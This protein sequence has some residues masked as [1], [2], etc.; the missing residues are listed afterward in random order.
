MLKSI[1]VMAVNMISNIL[2]IEVN[3]DQSAMAVMAADKGWMNNYSIIINNR[4]AL[5]PA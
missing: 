2:A 1:I 5:N 4:Y 3:I